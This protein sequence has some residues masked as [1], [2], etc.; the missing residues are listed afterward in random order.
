MGMREGLGVIMSSRRVEIG[1]WALVSTVSPL[2]GDL[3]LVSFF[4]S[5]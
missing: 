1:A 3:I 4:F 5:S 2:L